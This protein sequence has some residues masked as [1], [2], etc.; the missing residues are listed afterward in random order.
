MHSIKDQKLASL[1]RQL[2]SLECDHK[3]IKIRYRT[4]S[5]GSVMYRRQCTRCG[6]MVGSWIPHEKIL[7]K[8]SIEPID[9]GLSANYRKSK[10]ELTQLINKT[11]RDNEKFDFDEWYTN[12]L[13]SDEWANKRGLVFDR[14]NKICEGCRLKEATVVHHKTYANVGREFLFELVGVCERCH[15]EIH[16]QAEECYE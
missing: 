3:S 14:C 13:Q 6:E 5:N 15:T 7:K 4:A 16:K 2:A 11:I 10:F 8:E 1:E 9:D 12:Y